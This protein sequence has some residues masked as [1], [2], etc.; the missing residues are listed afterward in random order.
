MCIM[1]I[2]IDKQEGGMGKVYGV[3]INDADYVTQRNVVVDGRKKS[4]WRC[5]YYITWR[6][7]LTRCYS[8]P[9]QK[10]CPTYVGCTVAEEWKI[11]SNFKGWMETQDWEGKQL[12][13]DLLVE[14]N[15]RYG[16]DTCLFIPRLIN[17]FMTDSGAIRGD[18][19]IGARRS[20]G[21]YR[22]DCCN[23]FTKEQEYL[24]TFSC[25]E[26]AHRAWKA[27]KAEHAR[28]L[29]EEQTDKRVKKALLERYPMPY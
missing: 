22:V 19:P 23:P 12:D 4:V 28:R 15:K 27:K 3:G 1:C 24:G 2:Q 10:R 14:G 25:P 5:P 16:P 6:D 9:H 7:M 26:E 8:E 18:L 11:F 20:R 29:A 17:S 21:K 13:K